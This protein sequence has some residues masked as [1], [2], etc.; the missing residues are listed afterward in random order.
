MIDFVFYALPPF[1]YVNH[2]NLKDFFS[3]YIFFGGEGLGHGFQV[4]W[5]YDYDCLSG[6]GSPR[7]S[8]QDQLSTI[9]IP[10]VSRWFPMEQSIL[11]TCFWNNRDSFNLN[12]SKPDEDIVARRR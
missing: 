3:I 4:F 6:Q 2:V 11:L 8:L 9:C 10:F 1:L 12:K 7:L 5:L